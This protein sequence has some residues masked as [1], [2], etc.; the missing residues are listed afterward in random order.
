MKRKTDFYCLIVLAV[1]LIS[2]LSPTMAEENRKFKV[3]VVMSY[4]F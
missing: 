3:L 1:F 4:R 2:G